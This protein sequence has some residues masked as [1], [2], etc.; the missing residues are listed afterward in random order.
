[1]SEA[2]ILMSPLY[3][4]NTKYDKE[5][6]GRITLHSRALRRR[7]YNKYFRNEI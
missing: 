3:N 4:E 6:F 5:F 1:M 7:K 2:I